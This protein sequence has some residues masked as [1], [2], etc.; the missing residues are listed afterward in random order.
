MLLTVT[1][2]HVK[3]RIGNK[4]KPMINAKKISEG[5]YEYKGWVIEHHWEYKCWL[6][7]NEPSSGAT[8]A[9]NTKRDTMAMIDHWEKG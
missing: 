2:C 1:F 7:Y 8:D 9:A 3:Y 6:M 4:E 5:L